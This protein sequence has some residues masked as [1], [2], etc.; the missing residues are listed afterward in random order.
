MSFTADDRHFFSPAANV[1]RSHP[2]NEGSGPGLRLA[3][4]TA[5]P[6]IGFK[7]REAP[8]WLEARG[9]RLP[10]RP[11]R[12]VKRADGALIAALSRDEHLVLSDAG[13]RSS[14]C[15]ELEK[16]WELDERRLCYPVPRRHSHAWFAVG[17]P[18][19]PQM[20]AKLCGVDLRPE[21]FDKGSVAQTSIARLSG[22][23]VRVGED[24]EPAFYILADSASAEFLWEAMVDAMREFGCSIVSSD[25]FASR[26]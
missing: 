23:I 6:R 15:D 5:L 4:L 17:G 13:R 2:G 7:G 11:N 24:I 20:L 14:L 18:R 26:G 10:E 25:V 16:A 1:A 12:A 8:Q 9:C 3:D 19:A 22:I 21:H